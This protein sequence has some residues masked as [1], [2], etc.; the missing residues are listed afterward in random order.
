VMG[1]RGG[2]WGCLLVIHNVFSK[3]EKAISVHREEPVRVNRA[4]PVVDYA[5]SLITLATVLGIPVHLPAH[6]R[7]VVPCTFLNVGHFRG[8]VSKIS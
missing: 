4:G 5:E 8:F 7:T 2:D 1:G 3:A 6:P